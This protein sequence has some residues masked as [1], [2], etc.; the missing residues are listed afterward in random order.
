MKE[1]LFRVELS[2]SKLIV[3]QW[4]NLTLISEVTEEYIDSMYFSLYFSNLF[5]SKESLIGAIKVQ[6]ILAGKEPGGM[7]VYQKSA[8]YILWAKSGQLPFLYGA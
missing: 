7:S 2:W 4:F 3:T 8:N 6:I 5:L 1:T